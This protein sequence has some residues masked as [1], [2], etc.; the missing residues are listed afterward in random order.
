[1]KIIIPMEL[2]L[3]EDASPSQPHKLRFKFNF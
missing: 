3:V 1:M 2:G